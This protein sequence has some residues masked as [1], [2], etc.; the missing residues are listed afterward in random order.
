MTNDEIRNPKSERMTENANALA[1]ASLSSDFGIW[2]SF[3]ICHSSFVIH[4]PEVHPES[5][6]RRELGHG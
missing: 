6:R 4:S 2:I 3:G 1:A 5:N